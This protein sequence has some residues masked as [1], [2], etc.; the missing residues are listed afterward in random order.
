MWTVEEE[1]LMEKEYEEL[2][3]VKVE[4][5]LEE[6]FVKRDEIMSMREEYDVGVRRW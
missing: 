3:M 1:E 6:E 5:L 2:L 4:V